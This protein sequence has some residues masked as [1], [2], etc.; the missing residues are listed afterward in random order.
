MKTNKP[1]SSMT[2]IFSEAQE[3]FELSLIATYN[4]FF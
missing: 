1:F 2:T 4:L 3:H